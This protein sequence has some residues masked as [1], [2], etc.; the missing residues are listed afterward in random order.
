M[1][2]RI[3]SWDGLIRKLMYDGNSYEIVLEGDTRDR[4]D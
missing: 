1:E 3:I 2:G 4:E